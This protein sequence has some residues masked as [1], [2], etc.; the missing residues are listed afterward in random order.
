LAR[1][2]RGPSWDESFAALLVYKEANGHCDVGTES[3]S[4]G[5]WVSRQRGAYK[6]NQLPEERIARLDAIGFV[7]AMRG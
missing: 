4:L 6:K 3:G 5:K 2:Y 7:W 1:R